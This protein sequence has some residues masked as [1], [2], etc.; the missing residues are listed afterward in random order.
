M[1]RLRTSLFAAL[2]LGILVALPSV[3]AAQGFHAVVSKDGTD[4]WAVGD[5]G[6]VYRSLGGGV[7]FA[8]QQL[9][10]RPLRAIAHRGLTVLVAGDS[11]YVFRSADNG[12][13]FATQVISGAPAI[14]AVAL[15]S[16]TRAYAAGD[17]GTL[18]QRRRRR[19]VGAADERHGAGASRARVQRRD[20]GFAAGAGARCS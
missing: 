9:G 7:T 16:A 10:I 6:V 4:V 14:R 12:G 18:L 15:A 11:G 19:D 1:R 2:L 20:N 8:S 17:G 3:G 5:G 13:T